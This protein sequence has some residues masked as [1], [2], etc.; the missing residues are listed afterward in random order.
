M[1]FNSIRWRLP[2]SYG[3]IA[4]VAALS[5]GSVMLLVLKN[6]YA[7]QERNYL[8]GNA[9]ALRPLLE[10]MMQ[11]DLPEQ[12]LR[13]QI[14]SLSFLSQA[15][16]RLLDAN[17]NVMVDS[18]IPQTNQVVAVSGSPAAPM[19]MF[20]IPIDSD[21]HQEP[22]FIHST[23]SVAV[24]VPEPQ[25]GIIQ[26]A[27][28]NSPGDVI[29]PISA[30]PYGYGFS[31]QPNNDSDNRSSQIVNV[32]LNSTNGKVLGYLEFS[33][34][35]GYGTDIIR[36]V[37][38]AWLIA[39]LIAIAIAAFAGWFIS[40]QVTN[41]VLVLQDATRKMENGD[42]SVR[43]QLP[44]ER[45]DEFL[46]LANSFNGM[47]GQVEG[48]IST[49]RAF[50][51]DAAHE[52]HT[53]LTA[54]QANLELAREEKSASTRTRYLS[55]AQE[56][57]QRLEALVSS[58]LDLSRIE[59]ADNQEFTRVNLS[60]L[61]NGIAEQYASRA[62][63]SNRTFELDLPNETM[64]IFG[65][66]MQ[67]QQVFVNLLENALKFTRDNDVIRLSAEMADGQY[68]IKVV[69]TGIGI[70]ADDLPELFNRFHRGRNVSEIEGNGLGLAIVRAVVERHNGQVKVS[71]EDID[72]GSEF[73]VMLPIQGEK[74]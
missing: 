19:V 60:T 38:L 42:L 29:L 45:Q 59:A 10:Q 1:R 25:I 21:V 3:V 33:S 18:G 71:S 40:K 61:L 12:V 7:E 52:L 31:S 43:V 2:A 53:P 73:I 13:D 54:L 65:N 51:A 24:P 23:D 9:T 35:P 74:G 67:L 30:S 28:P 20:N 22:I 41:P 5:L 55:R 48:T 4:L 27:M 47:A 72:R 70:P 8:E 44:N 36:S 64:I 56:Q 68:L 57:V 46:S 49:L 58:L 32:P 34:G 11:S 66:E 50:V 37:T 15:R 26:Q 62:E 63:Q 14:A 69:D 16:I 17:E 6:Y 39:S